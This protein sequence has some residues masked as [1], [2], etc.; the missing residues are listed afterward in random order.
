MEQVEA[1]ARALLAQATAHAAPI[2]DE[3]A[4]L[5]LPVAEPVYKAH[6]Q[7]QE[8]LSA[9]HNLIPHM[10][11]EESA[12]GTLGLSLSQFRFTLALFASVILVAGV[13]L[14]RNPTR[15]RAGSAVIAPESWRP[16]R[17]TL[18]H[19]CSRRHKYSCSDCSAAPVRG[20]HGHP[21]HLLP[22]RQQHNACAA[23][24]RGRVPSDAAGASAG[25]AHCLVHRV[26]LSHL[27]VSRSFH[28]KRGPAVSALGWQGWGGEGWGRVGSACCAHQEWLPCQID[29][30]E[31]DHVFAWTRQGQ[32][33]RC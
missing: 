19:R 30:H 7:F 5:A 25:R 2:V 32:G 12:S 13:R 16:I 18:R 23:D 22:L 9:N 33:A 20:G 10:A 26:P 27:P 8:F 3:V 31:D 4:K 24:G 1:Q 14:F 6:L 29:K 21:D 11:W 15:K 17:C 28:V